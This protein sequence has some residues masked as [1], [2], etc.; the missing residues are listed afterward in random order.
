LGVPPHKLYYLVLNGLN[1]EIFVTT[2]TKTEYVLNSV[3]F[4]I[5]DK[6]KT[7]AT[8]ITTTKMATYY[9]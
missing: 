8:I 1:S 3:W 5:I 2:I 7:T 4:Y 9:G 6:I